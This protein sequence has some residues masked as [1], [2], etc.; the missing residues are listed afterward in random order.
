MAEWVALPRFRYVVPN[1]TIP[2]TA[3]TLQ[4][5]W[6]NMKTGEEAWRN[7]PTEVVS[8][9]EFNGIFRLSPH[10]PEVPK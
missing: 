4:Q 5:S 8:A 7:V 10:V 1:H 3:R 2:W 6:H 9:D